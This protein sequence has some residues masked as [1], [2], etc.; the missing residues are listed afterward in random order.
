[1]KNLEIDADVY[2]ISLFGDGATVHGMPL[3]NILASGV[4]EPSAVLAIVDCKF[5]L[6]VCVYCFLN[7]LLPE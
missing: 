1:M 5:F 7:M 2:G 4:G 6:V 3:L